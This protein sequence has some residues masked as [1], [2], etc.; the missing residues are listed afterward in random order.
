MLYCNLYYR[1]VEVAPPSFIK[2][3]HKMLYVRINQE[4]ALNL[5]LLSI[6]F[7]H[8]LCDAHNKRLLVWHKL[9]AL[10][11]KISRKLPCLLDLSAHRLN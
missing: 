11:I 8:H 9:R 1:L 5:Y 2:P 10:R 6:V 4:I 7:L 3:A